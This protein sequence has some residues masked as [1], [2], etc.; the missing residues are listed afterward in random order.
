MK[1]RAVASEI[2][3]AEDSPTQSLLLSRVLEDAGFRVHVA[4]DGLAALERLRSH[5][6]NLVISDVTMPGMDGYQLCR[7]IRGD[8]RLVALPV[9]LLTSLADEEKVLTGLE[10][11]ADAFI[12]KPYDN[13]RLLERIEDL[14]GGTGSAT[15]RSGDECEVLFARKKY[16]ILADRGRILRYL[17]S[18]YDN[19][20]QINA[21]LATSQEELRNVNSILEDRVRQRTIALTQEIEQRKRAQNSL[22]ATNRLLE[23]ANSSR[24]KDALLQKFLAEIRSFSGSESVTIRLG[25]DALGH[26]VLEPGEDT[27]APRDVHQVIEAAAAQLAAALKRIESE[28]QI[29]DSEEKYRQFFENDLAGSVITTAD[30]IIRSCNPAFASIFGFSSAEEAVG[31]SVLPLYGNQDLWPDFLT[32]M[33]RERRMAAGEGECRRRNGAPLFVIQS[34]VG[35]V[36]ESGELG[37]IRQYFV[38]ITEKK[39]LQSQ[40]FQ[41]QKMEA[42]GRLAGGVAHDFNNI[43]QVIQGFA[44]HLINKTP[45]EDPRH[46]W[47]K[48]IRLASDKA[49]ALINSLLAFSRKQE[50][51]TVLLN[52]N[53]VLAD[54][55]PM[56]R[57]FVGERV[58]LDL[59]PAAGLGDIQADRA[60]VEQLIM[61]MAANARD[62]MMEGGVFTIETSE[63]RYKTEAREHDPDEPKPGT[64]VLLAFRDTGTGMDRVTME[65]MFEPFYTTKPKGKGTGLGLATV[66]G[67]VQQAGGHIRCISAPGKGTEFRVHLPSAGGA[68]RG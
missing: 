44:D 20:L 38:D 11:G 48:Q 62:A 34:A 19:A 24:D 8:R 55:A 29:R 33:K 43:L 45:A 50:Q 41:S 47:L 37:E 68:Q 3:I 57:Q 14:L 63:T 6:P 54:M 39:S 65:H 4:P 10:A 18:T 64:Y 30:G 31:T 9:L 67:V 49:G 25:I 12:S 23:I 13:A 56:L 15:G 21:R 1:R 59:A 16:R 7:A 52:L 66:Y 60:Q 51:H 27:D 28:Q 53:A 61:N 2:L 42:I 5:V 32:R 58:R 40:L 46:N 35:N 36:D 17:I 26:I 22:Q